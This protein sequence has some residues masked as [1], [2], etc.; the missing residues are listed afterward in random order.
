MFI[1]Y[2]DELCYLI[3]PIIRGAITVADVITAK[4]QS[5]GSPYLIA[6]RKIKLELLLCLT[7]EEKG[8]LHNVVDKIPSGVLYILSLLEAAYNISGQ[9]KKY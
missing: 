8:V 6:L 4:C 2:S 5:K 7:R 9:Q 3:A 1:S